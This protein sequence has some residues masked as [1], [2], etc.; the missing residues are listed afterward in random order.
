M[1]HKKEMKLILLLISFLI[2]FLFLNKVFNFTIPCLFHEITNL[3]CPGCGITRMFLAL[4]KLDFYQAFRYNPLV[5]ILLILS[6]VYFLVK[7]IG[8]LNFKLPN[9]IYY[10]LLFIVIIYGIL[11]NIPLFSFLAPTEL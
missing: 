8:K 7:K 5:F 11:R 6:I 10:Y 4:F 9:Y 2:I 1:I 3:Y